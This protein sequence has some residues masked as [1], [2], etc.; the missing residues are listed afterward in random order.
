[1]KRSIMQDLW[2][3]TL[4]VLCMCTLVSTLQAAPIDADE[5]VMFIPGIARATDSGAIEFDVHAWLH[6]KEP[7]L[8]AHRVLARYLDL[9][10]EKL[11][12]LEG[13]QV[14]PSSTRRE[15]SM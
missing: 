12:P 11:S 14:V 9:D 15:P 6:E 1:M 4:R 2:R 8:M 7:L 5:E 13:E 3:Y 10:L